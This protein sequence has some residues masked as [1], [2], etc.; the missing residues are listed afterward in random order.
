MAAASSSSSGH[1]PEVDLCTGPRLSQLELFLAGSGAGV[2]TKT[3]TAPID[4]IR[5]LFQVDRQRVFSV[6][7]FLVE[8]NKIVRKEGV[9]GLWRGN[10][11]SVVRVIPYGGVQFAAFD[12]YRNALKTVPAFGA[13]HDAARMFLAGALAGMTATTA[14]YP[15]DL[16][17]T[18]I[19]V[20]H[21]SLY[22]GPRF[23]NYTQ[24]ATEIARV[25]GASAFFRGI[26]PTLMGIVP[27]AGVGFMVFETLKPWLQAQLRLSSEKDLPVSTR[28][29][30]GGIAG[31]VAQFFSYP[32]QVIRRRMQV[33]GSVGH[34]GQVSSGYTSWRDAFVSIARREGVVH[35]LYKGVSLTLLKGP[36]S[37]AV[38]FSINDFL[39]HLFQRLRIH[40]DEVAQGWASRPQVSA[41]DQVPEVP[42]ARK[43]SKVPERSTLL[44]HLF[45]G[46]VAG[47]CAKT[48]IA[49][50]D[51]MKILYQTNPDRPFTWR[52]GAGTIVTIYRRTGV[53]GLWRG[54]FATLMR[55][56]PFSATSF[57]MF[58][59]YHTSLNRYNQKGG[60]VI[61]SNRFFAGA[62]A[63]ATATSLTYP[64]ELMRA[65]MAAHWDMQP[66]YANYFEGFSSIIREEG[67]FALW[68]GLRPTLIGIMPYAGL[69]FMTFET[70]K[71]QF[72]KW[73]VAENPGRST[74]TRFACG[75][76]AGVV[77]QASTYPLD[78][79]RRRMQVHPGMYSSELDAFRT[80]YRKEGLR[81]GL[82]KGVTVNLV[83]GPI[84]VGVSFT[85]NDLMKTLLGVQR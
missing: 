16:L 32:F 54:H 80:I 19:A 31:F 74:A 36:L 70:L 25:E 46:G 60:L 59:V 1:K 71:K 56:I 21:S 44:E 77:A 48:V 51:R 78:I 68:K 63:G 83:K 20:T 38:G 34:H 33:Q 73:N 85:V 66:R 23:D 12:L 49:P 40:K 6:R 35:G 62:A 3:C 45:S 24:A 82:F 5:I 41:E 28:L 57:M 42:V 26:G 39:K 79:V 17:R 14:T 37:S 81:G 75:A 76:V 84:S 8:G 7:N 22:L 43:E 27:H 58:D 15:L 53:Q 50:G 55:V 65:R 47:A 52:K 9:T 18:R 4:R 29:A 13:E 2:T 72:L 64:L 69:S 11:A 10:V 61:V 67:F 30:A